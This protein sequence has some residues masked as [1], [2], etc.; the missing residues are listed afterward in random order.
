[1]EYAAAS[2]LIHSTSVAIITVF[3]FQT[4]ADQLAD[5]PLGVHSSVWTATGL[6]F[7]AV[8]ALAARSTY[9]PT[10]F[11]VVLSIPVCD[12]TWLEGLAK[13]DPSDW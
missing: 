4:E 8:Q 6:A 2:S 10:V 1:M 5:A 12:D 11:G 13:N 7:D 3:E 9:S